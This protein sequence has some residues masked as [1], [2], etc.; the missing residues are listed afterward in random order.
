MQLSAAVT[1]HGSK[2]ITGE[3][4]GMHPHQHRFAQVVGIA[5]DQ[6][7]MLTAVQIIGITNGEKRSEF[8][9]Q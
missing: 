4:F 9:R 1:T 5:F 7:D 6:R 3:A 2:G 8:R